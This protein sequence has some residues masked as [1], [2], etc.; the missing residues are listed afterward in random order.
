MNTFWELF[1]WARRPTGICRSQ[2]FCDDGTVGDVDLS[3]LV[4]QG[5]FTALKDTAAFEAVTIGEHGEL[6]W[7]EDLE[8]CGDALYLQISGKPPE[9]LFPNLRVH[10]DA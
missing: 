3:D 7:T 6:H 2:F 8:L 5:V 9:D 10:S 1:F 4:G